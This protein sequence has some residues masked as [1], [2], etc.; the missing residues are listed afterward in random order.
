MGLFVPDGSPETER[1]IEET[2]VLV[3]DTRA[4]LDHIADGEDKTRH[5]IEE[6]KRSLDEDLRRLKGERRD[7]ERKEGEKP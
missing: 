4:L 7:S 1:Q 5:H 2:K 6:L 3:R